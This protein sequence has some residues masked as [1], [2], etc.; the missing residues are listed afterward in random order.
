VALSEGQEDPGQALGIGQPPGQQTREGGGSAQPCPAV[1]VA[2]RSEQP[3]GPTQGRVRPGEIP[4]GGRHPGQVLQGPG[5][6]TL[7][8]GGRGDLVGGGKPGPGLGQPA[9]QEVEHAQPPERLGAFGGEVGGGRHLQRLLPTRPGPD[10]VAQQ[11]VGSTGD[12]ER[13]GPAGRIV[14]RVGL[15]LLGLVQGVGWPAQLKQGPR[16]DQPVIG[17]QLVTGQLCRPLAAFDG[18][19]R[20]AAGQRPPGRP[21]QGRHPQRINRSGRI[22]GA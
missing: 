13:G 6:A 1:L 22:V 9:A 8:G 4:A 18:Q 19:V 21:A 15:N 12:Q 16:L 20:L 11:A 3:G 7:V 2:L 14:V 10:G 5:L 17:R